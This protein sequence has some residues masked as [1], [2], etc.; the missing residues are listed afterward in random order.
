MRRREF[1]ALLSGTA[2]VWPVGGRA[3]QP[4]KSIIG[5]LGSESP[6]LWAGRLQEL[7]RGLGELGFVEGQNLSIEYR[8]AQGRNERL[9]SMASDLVR[10]QVKVII[11]PGSTPA[12]LAAQAATK[13]I[14]IVFEI[15]SDPV[16]L[17]LVS[18]LNKPGGN[19]TGVTTLNLE[20]GQKRLELLHDVIPSASIIGL[21]IN[22]TNPRLAETNIKIIQSAGRTF[23]LEIHVLHAST[24]DEFD[25]AFEEL[26]Q[27]KAGGLLI[28]ADP[29]FSSHVKQ[30]ATL[31]IRHAIPT[32]YQFREFAIA[33]GLLSYGT[34]FT[35]TFRTVG[36]YIGRILKGEK[37]ADLPAQQATAVE[38]II[39]QRTAESLGVTVPRALISRADEVIE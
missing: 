20:I 36:N 39:N 38:L 13:T 14:P 16:E 26:K 28:A 32:V 9:P 12:A 18:H 22:P 17:G 25:A 19:V 1:I 6:D 15:A 10:Q 33:G 11:A 8:W 3:Q 5:F 35:Q 34:S 30:L 27:I 4:P 24:E 31:S 2:A 29:F 7:H 21:L 37:P 23:G